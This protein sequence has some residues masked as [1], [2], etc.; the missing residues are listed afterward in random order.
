MISPLQR[1]RE[2]LI[3]VRDRWRRVPLRWPLAALGLALLALDLLRSVVR[4]QVESST[5]VAATTVM[6]GQWAIGV[7]ALI[8]AALA[9]NRSG[10]TRPRA[11]A[12][13][14][15]GLLL[16]GTYADHLQDVR[17]DGVLYYSYLRSALFDFDLSLGN[18][19]LAIDPRL[20]PNFINASP[21][22][23]PILWAPFVVPLHVGW[24]AARLFGAPAPN[25]VEPPYQAMACLATF[26]YGAIALFLLLDTLGRWSR[27]AIAFW[28]TVAVWLGS[29]L[30]FYLGT[31]PSFAHGCEFFAA[32][33]VLRA[34]L[35]LRASVDAR[36]AA[37]AGFACGL[38]FLVRSQDGLL[39]GL[40]LFEIGWAL[41]RGPT[42]RSAL[43]ALAALVL[44]F[45][46]AALPQMLV[47]QVMFGRPL[48]VPY[49]A[50]HGANFMHLDRPRLVD[51]LL[52]ARGGLLATYP[53][54][55]LALA[56]LIGSAF[57]RRRAERAANGPELRYLLAVLPVLVAAWYLNAT[58]FDWYQVRRFTGIMPLLAP[59]LLV[60]MAAL[61]RGSWIAPAVLALFLWRYDCA[62]HGLRHGPGD[63]APVRAVITGIGDGLA[64]QSL[65]L[66]EPLAPRATAALFSAYSD[67]APLEERVTR[68]PMG[69]DVV[70]L[71]LPWP[72]HNFSEPE[73]ED[74]RICRWVCNKSA[75]VFLLIRSPR[76]LIVSVDARALETPLPQTIEAHWNDCVLE[77]QTMEP[78]W[79]IYRFHAAAECVRAGVNQVVFAFERTPVYRRVRG[80]GPHQVR[81]A[82]FAEITL[83]QDGP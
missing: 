21:V 37:W 59:G 63:P 2:L 18:D 11:A 20:S 72:A 56:G 33:L 69:E 66:I 82:A 23:T 4:P 80:F 45:I 39:L 29:P 53:M 44:V 13:L 14:G 19:F 16:L 17:S 24:Q 74:G 79:R 54:T 57:S 83:H 7:A 10:V 58:I 61:G 15:L 68:F 40:P 12:M 60:V 51:T 1:L 47:W 71:R 5:S 6:L 62:V 3:T 75:T 67:E 78:S 73:V 35:A 52:S 22:G 25:G 36:R 26:V 8:V 27:P 41:L 9:L 32:V 46:L 64:A 81:P 65:R 49:T 42:R 70:T 38:L 77:R 50:L 43:R 55:L 28:T 31:L 34:W 48:L 30:R 76:A